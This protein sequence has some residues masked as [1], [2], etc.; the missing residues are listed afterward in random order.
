MF[1]QVYLAG[2]QFVICHRGIGPSLKRPV[3]CLAYDEL[4]RSFG[5][6]MKNAHQNI[7]FEVKFAVQ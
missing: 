5:L 7:V 2:S 1:I 6:Q 3:V 4:I